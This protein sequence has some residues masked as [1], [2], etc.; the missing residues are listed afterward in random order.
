V[1]ERRPFPWGFVSG[2]LVSSVIA[3]AG[4]TNFGQRTE[5]QTHDLRFA[6]RGPRES[7]AR[8]VIVAIG[9]RTQADWSEPMA[10]W[11]WHYA[12]LVRQAQK[13]G[14]AWVAFDVIQLADTDSFLEK[15][16]RLPEEEWPLRRWA[17]AI[18]SFE[19]RVILANARDV[20][21][22]PINPP[23][24]L[25]AAT[26]VGERVGYVDLPPSPDGVARASSPV[27]V[28]GTSAVPSL[29]ALIAAKMRG[30]EP[31]S[32][33]DMAKIGLDTFYINY[34]GRGLPVVEATDLASGRLSKEQ[35][36]LIR[37]ATL[38]VGTTFRGN[39]DVHSIP[40]SPRGPGVEVQAN[41]LSTLIDGRPLVRPV[42]LAEIGATIGIG[43]IAAGIAGLG[44][45]VV[46]IAVL[47][48]LA[49]LYALLCLTLFGSLD[50]L[51]PV[52]AP[53]A[54]ILLSPSAR[55]AV[56]SVRERVGRLSIES[57]LGRMNSR[58]VAQRLLGNPKFQR[59]G[60]AE[61]QMATILF[62]DIRN[63]TSMAEGRPAT[64]IIKELNEFFRPVLPCVYRTHG[65][66]NRFLGDGFLA[67][68]GGL[69]DIGNHA[70]AAIE[71]ATEILGAVKELNE[72]RAKKG[73]PPFE[74]GIGIHTGVVAMGNLGGRDR[75]EFTVIG[76]TVN[77]A[78]RLEKANKE[79]GAVIVASSETM[80]RL[81]G[82]R[83]FQGPKS[84][85]L[86]GRL[87]EIEAYYRSL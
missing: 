50:L 72:T 38:L 45:P 43:A 64:E 7:S 48:L 66:I 1:A 33:A 83:G 4:Q 19:G 59:A 70:E 54:A 25:I 14:A 8:I 39:P 52:T 80:G 46:A 28:D 23:D 78:A 62:L 61:D 87:Q 5:L 35:Q 3:V 67:I 57:L 6:W 42:P 81:D 40:A 20:W 10:F 36:L 21:G 44:S 58:E 56:T 55:F 17:E 77:I 49:A 79:L 26:D 85:S 75:H 18:N 51:L 63:S 47:A 30:L 11:P 76:D 12:D 53:L 13:L 22:I 34:L 16:G 73:K 65:I 41:A 24:F 86:S 84:L 27:I 15:Y 69:D 2:L 68:F 71:C 29:T 9:D 74:F 82:V 32:A 31:S 37:G 60:Y